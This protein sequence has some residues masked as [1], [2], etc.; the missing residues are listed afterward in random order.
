MSEDGITLRVGVSEVEAVGERFQLLLSRMADTTPVMDEI[1]G[2]LETRTSERFESGV[3]PGGVAWEKS[4]RARTEGG[5]TLSDSGRL[6]DSITRRASRDEAEVGT[7]VLYARIHQLGGK[8]KPKR[9]EFLVFRVGGDLIFA[10]EVTMPKR[11]FLG[12][13]AEDEVEIGAIVQ[14][15]VDVL[16]P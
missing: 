14:D 1:G 15:Y 4:F 13:D 16:R 11:E 6:G 8:I 2:Y 3:G 5:V 9:G 12:V 10:R 7:N